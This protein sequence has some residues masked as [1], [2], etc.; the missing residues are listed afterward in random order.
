MKAFERQYKI[1]KIINEKRNITVE[2][3][4]NELETS[5]R[6]ILRDISDLSG[7]LP[8]RSIQGRYGGGISFVDGYRY[9]DYQF[10]MT[11]EQVVVLN[12]IVYEIKKHGFCK[13]T[14]QEIEI[15]TDIIKKHSQTSYI[16]TNISS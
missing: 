5:K 7:F 9:C 12:K 13:L 15:V 4:A 8:I 10:Y 11:E 6:T 16:E 2:L 1:L 14:F 3:L